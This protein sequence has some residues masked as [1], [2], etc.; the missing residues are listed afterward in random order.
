M[1]IFVIFIWAPAEFPN[2]ISKPWF[3]EHAACTLPRLLKP[4]T[5]VPAEFVGEKIPREYNPAATM[6]MIN[7][8]Q[9]YVIMYSR[10][11]WECFEENVVSLV[12]RV[13][14]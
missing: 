9:P 6:T 4:V 10:A 5:V 2:V 1:F 12:V 14:I 7:M 13:D 3:P 11:D 8:A